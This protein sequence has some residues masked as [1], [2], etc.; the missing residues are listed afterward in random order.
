MA[1]SGTE[2]GYPTSP[3]SPAYRRAAGGWIRRRFGVEVDPDG[4]GGGLRRD[5]GVRGLH[6]PVPAPALP[7]P[8]HRPLP[9]GL[10]PDLRHGGD[11][12]RCRAV[13][14]PELGRRRTGPRRRRSRRRGP[15]PAAVGELA[16]QPDRAPRPTWTGRRRGGGRTGSRS[17]PTSA[18]PSSPGTARPG[19][20]S[21]S[22]TGR[23]GGRALAV[24]A[25][26]PGRG[27]GRVL[28]RGPGPG[29]RTCSTCAA[30]PA[31]WSPVRCR[32]ARWWRSTTTTTWRCSAGGTGSAW[33]SWPTRPR[34][35]RAAR[36]PARR[37]LLPVGPGAGPP[38]RRVGAVRVAGRRAGLL[39]SPGELYGD[40]GGGHVRVAVV[41]PMDRL[42]LVAERLAAA[43]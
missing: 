40:D 26:E 22:G 19:A 27:A 5:Q 37:R 36:R 33:P 8:G 31:S 38:R 14:V 23:C 30:T 7:G 43:L 6:R 25:L 29:R 34:R 10:L 12:G 1:T 35:G 21:E 18:T 28:R 39:V 17:S 11:P 3:G 2:R 24:E 4:R 9:V 16:V 13:A 42:E 41:Q 15:G 32:P 20:S